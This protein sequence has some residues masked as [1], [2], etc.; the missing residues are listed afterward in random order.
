M[1]NVM[2]LLNINDSKMKNIVIVGGGFGGIKVALDLESQN[3]TDSR[4]TLISSKSHFE[5]QP[6]LYRV[7]SGSN[8]LEVCIPL[9]EIFDNR[10]IEVIEDTILSV[11]LNNQKLV[12][13]SE[14]IYKFDYLVLA[15][16]SET[17][18]Y[19]IPGLEKFSFGM[20]SI[21]EAIILNRHIHEL[22]DS[23]SNLSMKDQEYAHHFVVVGGGA[24]GVELSAELAGYLKTIATNHHNK[25]IKITI[26]LIEAG[27][28]IL[29]LMPIDYSNKVKQRL[30]SLGV[31]IV[32]NCAIVQ[33]QLDTIYAKNS[34]L[35]TKT[36]IWTAGV[37]I[38]HLYNNIKGLEIN[39][40]R[41]VKIDE[42]L[43]IVNN[44]NVFVIG[45]GA[46]SQYSGMAQTAIDQGLTVANNI[47]KLINNKPLIPYT[48]K[49]TNYAI[50]VGKY[51]AGV[52]VG[53]IKIYGKLAWLIRRLVDLK[54]FMSIL[55]FKKA[56]TVWQSGKT[57]TNICSICSK[58]SI[59]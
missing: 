47:N 7:V 5:Y 40:D 8:P 54:Y 23:F 39:K 6:A 19:N 53:N 24:S 15:M 37:K 25:S 4:I 58:K 20:K 36:V 26:D 33:E 27:P 22:F 56:I 1:F 46:S 55:S 44:D 34:K 32:V 28:N 10:N 9:G 16:G 31:N 21:N 18:Y 12:G 48:P 29:S 59:I 17:E 42:Y 49:K 35:K 11:D 57:L 50:P 52:M 2:M 43:K 38:N 45:D 13:L 41:R 3:L 51:W 30:K 14:S